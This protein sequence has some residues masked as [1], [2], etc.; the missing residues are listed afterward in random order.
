[1]KDALHIQKQSY[2]GYCVGTC[3]QYPGIVMYGET[4][5]DLIQQFKEALPIHKDA[6]RRHGHDTKSR[7]EVVPIE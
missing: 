4:D 2:D 3:I 7:I 5:K 6:L 1:M